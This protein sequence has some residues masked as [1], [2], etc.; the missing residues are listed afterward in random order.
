M[1]KPLI[2]LIVGPLIG[3]GIL[4]FASMNNNSNEIDSEVTQNVEIKDGVQYI[5][6]NA[7]GGYSPRETTAQA[8]MPTKL[9]V[10]TNGTYDCSSALSLRSIGYQ[11][12]LPSTGEEVID[13]GNPQEGIFRGLCSMGMYG[14]N[15]N[16]E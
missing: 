16:F 6:V 2:I 12:M 10:K 5:T 4:F 15:I 1:Q 8:N 7:R 14:F 9:I 3:I 11:K 13:L